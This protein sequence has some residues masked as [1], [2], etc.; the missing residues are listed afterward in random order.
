MKIAVA[1]DHA[2]FELKRK[3]LEF[4]QNS[5][6]VKDLGCYSPKSV[7][8]PDFA[9]MVAKKVAGGEFDRGILI[10]GTGIGMSIVA[11]RQNG[12]RAALCHNLKT[13]KLSRKHNDAN[14][15]SLGARILNSQRAVRIVEAW[16]TTP[17]ESG[18][19]LQRIRKIDS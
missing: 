7:D 5:H 14:I 16:L 17:F 10:C 2:G 3:I 4:L 9:K 6:Q 8:Y 11:N 13:A 18:R 19:H 15:L 1:A 12:I